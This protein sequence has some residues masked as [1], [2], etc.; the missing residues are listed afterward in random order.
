MT[1]PRA[2]QAVPFDGVLNLDKPAGHTSAACV[3]QVKRLLPRGVKIGH[4]G[5][6]DRFATGVLLLLIGRSTKR[7]EELMNGRKQYLATIKLGATT[8]TLDPE[9]PEIITP[10]SYDAPF[11]PP[12][13][14][15]VEA[16]LR[17]F[18]GEIDQTPPDFSA[19]KIAGKRASDRVLAGETIELKPRCVTVY[20][21]TLLDYAWPFVRVSIDCGRGFYVRAL[22]RDLGA[23]LAV[24][25]YLVEL[26]RTR[27]GEFTIDTAVTLDDLTRTLPV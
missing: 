12:P 15:D 16:V 4:A 21:V 7:C 13:R 10:R 1:D 19:L 26:R 8:A 25:G 2:T 23:A 6:L 11:I 3:G 22:A 24:G 14:E 17:T 9:Q 18:V 20:D 27:V 5:T